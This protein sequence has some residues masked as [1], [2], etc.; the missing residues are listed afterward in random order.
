MGHQGYVTNRVKAPEDLLV[1]RKVIDG[2]QWNNDCRQIRV[3]DLPVEC[4]LIAYHRSW[5]LPR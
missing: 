2:D 3:P 1:K 5:D 4:R